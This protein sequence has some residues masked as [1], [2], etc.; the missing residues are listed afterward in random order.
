MQEDKRL[1]KDIRRLKSSA[2]RTSIWSDKVEAS[3]IGAADK[4]FVGHKSAKMMKRSKNIAKRQQAAIEQKEDLLKN[5][6]EM[7]SL[8][9]KPLLHPASVL[10]VQTVH[11]KGKIKNEIK[12]PTELHGFCTG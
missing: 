5:V 2:L 1:R 9:M 7:E 11:E 8:Q 10:S 12:R 6:E 3:K 4:G